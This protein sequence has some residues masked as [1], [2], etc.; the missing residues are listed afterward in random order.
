MESSR[1]EAFLQESVGHQKVLADPNEC[2]WI[3]KMIEKHP[4]WK[5]ILSKIDR[6]NEKWFTTLV[7]EVCA[8]I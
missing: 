5:S 8:F 3:Y 7:D 6:G 1:I 2:M 4:R